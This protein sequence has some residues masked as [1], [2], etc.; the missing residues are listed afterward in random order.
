[1]PGNFVYLWLI[2]VL[3]PKARVIHCVRDPLDTC[4]SAYFQN[5]AERN[6]F[7]FSLHTLAKYYKSYMELMYHW[8]QV[9]TIT[10][11]DIEYESIVR[12]TEAVSRS[13]ID[14]CGLE[15]DDRC[16]Q[17]YNSRHFIGTA[18]CHQVRRPIYNKSIGR[19]K[20]YE[21]HLEPLI[22]SLASE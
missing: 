9:L 1:M 21:Q 3:F 10:M 12:N 4:I 16:L 11:L 15:W 22:R 20:K 19:W 6:L 8:K 14:F 5:F 2:E 18:S 7:T 17:F 13:M